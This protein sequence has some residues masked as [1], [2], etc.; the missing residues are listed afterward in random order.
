M[1]SFMFEVIEC[2]FGDVFIGIIVGRG[3]DGVG[4]IECCE[5]E[6]DD[7]WLWLMILGGFMGSVIEVGVFGVEGVGEL[8][9]V[10]GFMIES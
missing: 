8:I 9:E 1:L 7:C 2:G 3:M 5:E 6:N 4:E 10:V